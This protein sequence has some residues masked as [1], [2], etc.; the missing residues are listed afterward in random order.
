MLETIC[1][2]IH[3]DFTSGPDGPYGRAAGRFEV[4][5]G[6]LQPDFAVSGGYFLVKGSRFNDGVHRC[7]AEDMTDEVFVGELLEM[8]PPRAFLRLVEE[9]ESWQR[10]YGDAADGPYKSE[11]VAGVYAYTRQSPGG[12]RRAFADRLDRWRRMG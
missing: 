7:P 1:A 4:K 8:R 6:A 9:I 3:N 5:N 12:W 2:H 10:R 11:S